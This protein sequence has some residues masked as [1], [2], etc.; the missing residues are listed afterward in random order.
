LNKDASQKTLAT[1][2]FFKSCSDFQNGD[3]NLLFKKHKNDLIFSAAR[4]CLIMFFAV[5]YLCLAF[6]FLYLYIV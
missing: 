5:F 6:S 3:V 4:V 2:N 1:N